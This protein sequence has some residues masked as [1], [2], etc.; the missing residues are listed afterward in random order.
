MG[1]F[2][3]LKIFHGPSGMSR[4]QVFSVKG[5]GALRPALPPAGEFG[6]TFYA[7]G[8]W[9]CHSSVG[10]VQNLSILE[11]DVIIDPDVPQNLLLVGAAT[12]HESFGTSNLALRILPPQSSRV[13]AEL[14]YTLLAERTF[15]VNAERQAQHEG[16]RIARMASN[17]ISPETHDSDEAAY[18]DGSLAER[19]ALL[20]NG[21]TFVF[22]SPDSLGLAELFLIHSDAEPRNTPTL[23]IRFLAPPGAVTP[24]GYVTFSQDENDD[25][26]DLWGNWTD[27]ASSYGQGALIG[28]FRFALTATPPGPVT[29]PEPSDRLLGAA[30]L[31]VAGLLS[32]RRPPRKTR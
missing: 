27:A 20:E 12:N 23:S 26:V 17:Y 18:V 10:F 31:L 9:D 13:A 28:D 24:Q 5:N 16:F 30:G 2:S 6:A 1:T 22:E 4:P 32:A 8:Y 21:D 15:C 25:N 7:T 14:S 29:L 3:E 19:R 11:L